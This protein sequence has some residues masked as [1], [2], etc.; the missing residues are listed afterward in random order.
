MKLVHKAQR[1]RHTTGN[2]A[3]HAKHEEWDVSLKELAEKFLIRPFALLLDPTCFFV[4]LY[5]SFVF[6]IIYL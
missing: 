2:W 4:S 5:G 6:G 3:L 1:L